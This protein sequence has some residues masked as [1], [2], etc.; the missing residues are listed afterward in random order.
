MVDFNIPYHEKKQILTQIFY[1]HPDLEAIF[2]SN[3]IDA[4]LIMQIALELGKKLP[5]D[6]LLVG[7]DGTKVIQNILPNLT[8]IVQPIEAIA[9]TAVDV[10]KARLNDH[11]TESEYVLPVS[12]KKGT[13]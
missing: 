13:T 5:A 9:Q 8:T 2:A 4:A 1:D 6:L 7:Y 10:L 12:L 3:D 11:P